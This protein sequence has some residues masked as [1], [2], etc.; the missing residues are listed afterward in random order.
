MTRTRIVRGKIIETTGGDYNIYTK[1]NI[2]YSAGTT[3]TETG[4]EKGVS[5]GEP[6][7]YTNEVASE[8]TIKILNN[9]F[10]PLGIENVKGEI[11]NKTI[12]FEIRLRKGKVENLILNVKNDGTAIFTKKIEETIRLGDKIIVDW[13]GFSDSKIYD[14][15]FFTNGELV[16]ELTGADNEAKDTFKSKYDE[17]KWVDIKIDDTAKKIDV[18]LRVDLK[19]GGAKGINDADKVSKSAIT[20][21]NIQPFIK[22]NKSYE[23]L[24]KMAL[25]GIDTYWSRTKSNN[26]KN[27]NGGVLINGNVYE[28]HVKSI[29]QDENGMPAPEITY[30]TN[31]K[32]NFIQEILGANRSRNWAL[33]RKLFYIEG[34]YHQDG[35]SSTTKDWL[36]IYPSN[37]TKDFIET[38]AH[39][40]GHEILKEYLSFGKSITHKGSSS[41]MQSPNGEYTYPKNGG[42]IDIM[43]Y[44][45]YTEVKPIDFYDRVIADE[46]DV[47]GLLWCSKLKIK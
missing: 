26:A 24:K 39:E 3:I 8:V 17:V 28:V 33:S 6:E 30:W 44:V 38:A 35:Y 47:L 15:T 20:H 2:V 18:I 14:S 16:V 27:K 22:Q 13:D 21:Y 9:T 37:A 12:Q 36:Y 11:E 5:Y 40:L 41:V 43:K 7:I 19:D 4:V 1:E 23:D 46:K 29:C 45:E 10:L 25:E 32:L 31:T 42:E 34:Y